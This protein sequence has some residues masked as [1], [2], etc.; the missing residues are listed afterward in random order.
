MF[1]F[2]RCGQ[3]G[4]ARAKDIIIIRLVVTNNSHHMLVMETLGSPEMSCRLRGGIRP[5]IHNFTEVLGQCS[6]SF[7]SHDQS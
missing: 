6:I 5:R 2:L 1:G 4:V 7:L 3:G